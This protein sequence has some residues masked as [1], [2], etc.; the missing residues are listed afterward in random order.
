MGRRSKGT[1]PIGQIRL[2]IGGHTEVFYL[3]TE[4]LLDRTDSVTRARSLHVAAMAYLKERNPSSSI[5]QAT[6]VTPSDPKPEDRI[7]PR[8]P[9]RSL[10]PIKGQSWS[11]E[12]PPDSSD[13]MFA[14]LWDKIWDDRPQFSVF[15]DFTF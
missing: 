4:T 14:E 5:G 3:Q 8:P 9:F 2:N 13:A 11:T 10:L 12:T 7:L 6:C 1:R 15:S